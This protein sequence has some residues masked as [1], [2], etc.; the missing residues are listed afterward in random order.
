MDLYSAPF[1]LGQS[2]NIKKITGGVRMG[3]Y[4]GEGG[5]KKEEQLRYQKQ[6]FNQ[7]WEKIMLTK[8]AAREF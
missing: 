7:G 3:G 2:A 8:H 1:N 4:G 5:G 6:N